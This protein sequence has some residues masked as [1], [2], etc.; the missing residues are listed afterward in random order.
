[1][2]PGPIRL[3]ELTATVSAADGSV[4]LADGTL[5]GSTLSLDRALRNLVTF[6]G[7]PLV[8]AVGTVTATPAA[9]LGLPDRGV[10]APGAV[11][12]LVLLTDTG[13]VVATVV[14]GEVA[15]DRRAAA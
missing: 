11:G 12:D 5:A 14:G 7:V 6:A 15:Y 9:V 8:D 10:V 13:E 1:M 4:R 3:G 2:P